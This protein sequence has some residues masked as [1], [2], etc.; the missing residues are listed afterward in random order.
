MLQGTMPGVMVQNNGGDP[1]STA[2]LSIRGRGS[3]GTDND[4]NS[5]DGVLYVVDGVPGAPFNIE[6]IE[7]ITILKDAAS[8]AIYG[9]SVG[10]GGVVVITTKQAKA[11]QVKISV[12][13]SKS[14]KNAMHLP[15]VLTSQEYNKVWADAVR[16]YG[17]TLPTTADA[18]KY[19]YGAVT[20]TDW[21]DEIFRT[22]SLEHYALSL[23]GGSDNLKALASFNFDKDQGVL[24]NT[25][26]RKF[27]GK[28]NLDFK[29][30]K[31]ISFSE[32]VY[33]YVLK[34]TR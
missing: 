32:Q 20:R 2:S 22:G 27:G 6:D 23:S 26:A 15:S 13:I 1:L 4:Y 30:N 8:A 28:V 16:L 33:L 5:G 18:S 7:S 17:G 34:W 25:F 14:I 21:I 12:N 31:Y 24:L 3:R 11:G 9:A 10:S 29:V 19:A